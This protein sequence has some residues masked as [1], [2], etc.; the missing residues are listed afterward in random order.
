MNWYKNRR[1]LISGGAGFIGS[2]LAEALVKSEA[3]VTIVDDF[4]TGTLANIAAIADSITLIGGS[5]T[6][7]QTC[8]RACKNQEIVFHCAAQ[9]SVPQSMENPYCCYTTNVYG[10]STL[11]HAAHSNKVKRFI[12]S[13]SSA[14]YGQLDGICSE[15]VPC[16]PTSPY[17]MSKLLGEQLCK[18]YTDYFNLETVSLRY[19]NV[20]GERQNPFGSY[21]S[22]YAKFKYNMQNNHPITM[23]GD[24]L[25]TRDFIHVAEVVA[26]NLK[27]GMLPAKSVSG[28]IFNVATGKS[29]TLLQLLEQLK[30]QEFPHFDQKIIFAP[31]RTGDIRNIMADCSKFQSLE[32]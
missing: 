10:T 32:V 28:E 8:M 15:K 4:S 14:V 1:V 2:H 7:L 17:G 5:I 23:F 27:V 16:N 13:S 6:D 24:G 9:T 30:S 26:S 12:F 3:I 18:G 20:F 22:A 25:Q 19:F 29:I 21:A 31:P 11:L